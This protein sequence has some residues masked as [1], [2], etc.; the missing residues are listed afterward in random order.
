MSHRPLVKGARSFLML[1]EYRSV[2]GSALIEVLISVSILSVVTFGSLSLTSIAL[3]HFESSSL[4]HRPLT[5]PTAEDLCTDDVLLD[6]HIIE[7]SRECPEGVCFN[8]RIE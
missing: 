8:W 5:T 6:T 2:E 1:K 4:R 3:K 7:C